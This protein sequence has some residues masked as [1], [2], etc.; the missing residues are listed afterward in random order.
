MAWTVNQGMEWYRG[1]CWFSQFAL[2]VFNSCD[3]VL[4]RV[5]EWWLFDPSEL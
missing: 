2:W 1:G 4:L 3:E 5:W